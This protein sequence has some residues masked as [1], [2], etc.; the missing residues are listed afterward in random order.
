MLIKSVYE[1]PVKFLFLQIKAIN[2]KQAC[3]SIK[4]WNLIIDVGEILHLKK[5]TSKEN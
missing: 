3:I 1:R 4:K 5:K 2:R